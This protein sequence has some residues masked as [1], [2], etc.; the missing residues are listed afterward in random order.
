MTVREFE[1]WKHIKTTK[2]NMMVINFVTCIE[3]I[4]KIIIKPGRFYYYV[5]KFDSK[6]ISE[7][8]WL[9]SLLK[10]QEIDTFHYFKSLKDIC[11]NILC[12]D[13]KKA[14]EIIE[15]ITLEENQKLITDY[16]GDSF[17]QIPEVKIQKKKTKKTKEVD[18]LVSKKMRIETFF[19]NYRKRK[20]E[21]TESENTE[22]ENIELENNNSESSKKIKL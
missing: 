6:S 8:M 9:C 17:I 3:D 5:I 16:F 15:K 11:S 19:E 20:L 1:K 14:E 22:S 7:K 2:G 21:N 13:V 12:C 4:F 18:I 10:K